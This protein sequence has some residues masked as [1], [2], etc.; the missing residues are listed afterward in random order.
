M[1]KTEPQPQPQPQPQQDVSLTDEGKTAALPVEPRWY[2]VSRE[3]VATLCEHEADAKESAL[4]SVRSW[5][6]GGPHRAVCLVD[7]GGTEGRSAHF[8][9]HRAMEHGLE[10]YSLR[11]TLEIALVALE[12]HRDQTRPVELADEAISALRLVVGPNAVLT[13]P[14]NGECR[15]GSG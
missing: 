10:N 6:Q 2:C 5:P 9:R 15:D 12:Y 13:G 3:G 8:W 1:T 14:G 4:R 11:T 7:A